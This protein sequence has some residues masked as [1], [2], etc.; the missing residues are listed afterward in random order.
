[1]RTIALFATALV[2][3]GTTGCLRVQRD[4]ATGNAD[5][6]VES[7][8]KRGEDWKGTEIGRAHV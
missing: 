7:P 8:L 3:A 6:D 5:V 4:P 2:V 1:M